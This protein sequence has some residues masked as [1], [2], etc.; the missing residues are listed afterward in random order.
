M[1]GLS[2]MS[3]TPEAMVQ[4]LGGAGQPSLLNTEMFG[5]PVM[6]QQPSPYMPAPATPAPA[7]TD[8][9]VADIQSAGSFGNW[10]A[11]HPTPPPAQGDGSTVAQVQ[12]A[13]GFTPL[14]QEP[15]PQ[16]AL[17][18]PTFTP[19]MP[20][21]PPQQ[22]TAAAPMPP[23]AAQMVAALQQ[24]VQSAPGGGNLFSGATPFGDQQAS[25]GN[26]PLQNQNVGS[27]PLTLPQTNSQY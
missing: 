14:M 20:E 12:A 1:P 21:L 27:G 22:A 17:A 25:L 23:D 11:A 7:Q 3:Q 6:A 10:Y 4:A 9:T 13:G 18:P 2:D 8:P 26:Q 24:P 16:M 5:S 19:L 15:T